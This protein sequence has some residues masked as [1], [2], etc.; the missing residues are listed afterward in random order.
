MNLKLKVLF[1]YLC[2]IIYKEVYLSE[3]NTIG[4]DTMYR[5][6]TVPPDFMRSRYG[7][8]FR[9]WKEQIKLLSLGA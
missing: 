4:G 7:C 2:Y 9:L 3:Y 5:L 8:S 6:I 1:L